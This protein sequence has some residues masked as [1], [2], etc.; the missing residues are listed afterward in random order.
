MPS[1]RRLHTYLGVFIAPSVLFFALTGIVQL[2]SLHEARAGYQPPAILLALGSVHK[3]QV[4]PPAKP[5]TP[6]GGKAGPAGKREPKPRAETMPTVW[7]YLLKW[8][9]VIMALCLVTSTSLGLY[10]AFKFTRRP[11]LCWG[12]VTAGTLIP[13]ALL[14]A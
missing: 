5:E 1:V 8:F 3:N 12:L 6:K 10:L 2:F 4:L 14:F 11:R 9:F 13:L 7:T